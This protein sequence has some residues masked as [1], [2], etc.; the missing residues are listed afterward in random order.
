MDWMFLLKH[1]ADLLIQWFGIEVPFGD[2]S[3]PVSGI[4]VFTFLAWMVIDFL[5]RMAE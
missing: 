4:L 2:F 5:K 3:I 1:V